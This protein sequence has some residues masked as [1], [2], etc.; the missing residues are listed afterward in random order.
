M[1]E[2]WP[3]VAMYSQLVSHCHSAASRVEIPGTVLKEKLVKPGGPFHKSSSWESTGRLP[4]K[5]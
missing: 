3:Q 5:K 2:L 4:P 1:L